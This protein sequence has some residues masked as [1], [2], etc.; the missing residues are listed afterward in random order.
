MNTEINIIGIYKVKSQKDVHLL[1]LEI[2]TNPKN[3]N[4]GEFTQELGGIDKYNWQVPWDEKFLDSSGI[5]VIGDWMNTP[6]DNSDF[7]R[8]VFFLHFVDFKK[9]L[10]TQ[11]GNVKLKTEE[12]MPQRLLNLITYEK[13]F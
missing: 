8:L 2:R 13:P 12:E 3:I 10:S 9:P 5:K 7:T 4:I 11:F 6:E 1:E